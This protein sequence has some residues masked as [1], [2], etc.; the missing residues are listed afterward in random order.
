MDAVINHMCGSGVG[1]GHGT[2]G[3]WF[4]SHEMQ[5]SGVP[6]GPTDFNY[7]DNSRCPTSSCGIEDYTDAQQ[8]QAYTLLIS[9]PT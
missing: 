7:C 8:V 2:A 3:S 9:R 5:F 6:Y 4:N 1:T